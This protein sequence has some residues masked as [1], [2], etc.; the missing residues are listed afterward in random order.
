MQI[1]IEFLGTEPIEN[2]VTCLNY[3]VDKVIYFGYKDIIEKQKQNLKKFLIKYCNVQKVSF[4]EVPK[5]DLQ[6]ILQ[7]M[8]QTIDIAKEAGAEIFFDVTGGEG[9]LLLAFGMLAKDIQASMHLYDFEENHF[10]KIDNGNNSSICDKARQQNTNFDIPKYIELYGG[11]IN[12]RLHKDIKERI[13]S[14]YEKEV[15]DLWKIYLENREYWNPFSD[16]IRKNMPSST[17]NQV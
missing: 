3:D 7:K 13:D 12:N 14:G 9:I 11:C 15:L 6:L 2:V 1:N 17:M 10:V 8:K 16:F 5:I 4:I